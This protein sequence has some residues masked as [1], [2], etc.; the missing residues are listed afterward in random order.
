MKDYDN[1]V[2]YHSKAWK[3]V[4]TAYMTSKSYICERCGKPAKICHHRK[5]LD[6]INVNDPTVALNF[7]NLEALCQDCHNKEHLSAD[8]DLCQ[9]DKD[10]NVTFVRESNETK[11]FNKERRKIDGLLSR[12]CSQDRSDASEMQ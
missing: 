12:I 6:G 2:F 4:S 1:S 9:F 8:R 5:H 11:Q 10:G 3:R 7:D